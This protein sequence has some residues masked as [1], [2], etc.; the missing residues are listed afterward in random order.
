M[1]RT[2][3]SAIAIVLLA[4]SLCAAAGPPATSPM[5]TD[6]KGVEFF[7][8]HIR[9]VLVTHCYKCHSESSKNIKGGLLLDSRAGMHAGGDSGAAVVPGKPA[10]S[11]LLSALN[12]K[13]FE[14]PPKGKLPA[15]VI[16]RFTEWV[17]MGAP[18]P[19]V[20]KAAPVYAEIDIEA[21]RKFWAFQP[22]KYASPP[23]VRNKN[24]AASDIDRFVLAQLEAA[25]LSPAADATPRTLLRRVHNDLTGL[26]PT[27]AEVRKFEQAC[28]TTSIEKALAGVVDKLLASPR[29]GE[30]WGRHW[31]DV[32]R[33]AESNG[34]VR[35]STFPHAWRYRDYVIDAFNS[36]MPYDQFV[37]E[38]IAGDLLPAKNP[39]QRN[40]QLIATGFL[41]L[42]PKPV[43]K[44]NPNFLMDLVADQLEVTTKGFMALTVTCARC[45]DHKF[46]PFPTRDYYAMAGIFRSTESLYGSGGAMGAAPN[47]DLH[48]LAVP[49]GA[50]AEQKPQPKPAAMVD[51]A[52]LKRR[53]KTLRG[54]I[55]K[56]GG[57]KKQ[58]KPPKSAAAKKRL[59]EL[60][61]E[62]RELAAKVK[63]SGKK[64][65]K[66]GGATTPQ[67]NVAMG[68][69]DRATPADVAINIR[70]EANKRGEIAPR[71]FLQVIAS[72][73]P[74]IPTNQSGRLELAR[75]LTSQDHPLTARVMVNRVWQHLFGA[76]IVR[77]PD[78]FGLH[79]DRPSHPELLDYLAR[80]FMEDGWSVKQLIRRMVLSRVYR[81]SGEATDATITADPDN[82]LLSR[83]PPRRLNAESLRDSILAISGS[84]DLKHP[85]PSVVSKYG[86][87]LVQDG[88]T[89]ATFHAPSKHRTV[90]LPVVR[91]ALPDILSV[92][93]FADP[94][95]VMG[96]RNS[97]TVPAQALYLMNS[98][99]VVAQSKAMATRI[100]N[101]ARSDEARIAA[102]YNAALLR[103]PTAEEVSRVLQFL[104]N[105][106]AD[107]TEADASSP[108]P[109]QAR[110]Q[111]WESFCQALFVSSEFRHIP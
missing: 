60:Q 53:L 66:R 4:A 80:G 13:D 40:R 28:K 52:Q 64:K 48:R 32:A 15:A 23:A 19:R 27:Y 43:S 109:E 30:R 44:G 56:L 16:A 61:A 105:I 50:E 95:L 54:E 12:Q 5:A 21:G 25:K 42:A 76:G 108:A 110:T 70:G 22:V 74:E 51:T 29:F 88:L 2:I 36:N 111:A 45:H 39:A 107:I 101:E 98:P 85:G 26:P 6:A 84:I 68:A 62:V 7:E 73:K 94:S 46:D 41:A 67:K 92:F 72:T 86:N 75:W 18:D 69:R 35:N 103:Q 97:T 38:Q 78:N 104:T 58:P 106:A 93:D 20:E 9:P 71:G 57:K 91:N 81:M 10:A 100:Q 90:Y 17:K 1:F 83:R 37:H 89:A 63:K 55:K 14:M 24:W 65:G 47:T 49:G 79:G 34:N 8:K 99:F 3:V 59:A 11:L 96:R 77:T 82:R 102:A 31:L 33:Y 87:K